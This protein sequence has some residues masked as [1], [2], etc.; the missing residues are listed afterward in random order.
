MNEAQF[1]RF[2]YFITEVVKITKSMDI[3]RTKLQLLLLDDFRL[4]CVYLCIDY[5]FYL[6][7]EL[8]IFQ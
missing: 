8:N 1:G 6:E 4:G 5:N 3:S 7:S 2:D